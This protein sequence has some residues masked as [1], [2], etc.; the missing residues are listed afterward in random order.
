LGVKSTFDSCLKIPKVKRRLDPQTFDARPVRLTAL[1]L[2]ILF[3]GF[4]LLSTYGRQAAIMILLLLTLLNIRSIKQSPK[5]RKHQLI[6]DVLL[7]SIALTIV[8]NFTHR[9]EI[10]HN[11]SNLPNPIRISEEAWPYS[12]SRKDASPGKNR[13]QILISD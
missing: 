3:L 6:L 8:G 9:N 12:A 7:I 10:W 4:S 2:G 11:N 13:C 5:D 1:V